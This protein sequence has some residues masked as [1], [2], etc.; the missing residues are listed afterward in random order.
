MYSA[1]AVQGACDNELAWGYWSLNKI[2]RRAYLPHPLFDGFFAVHDHVTDELILNP[3]F[4]YR[5]PLREKS[6]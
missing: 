4:V 3:F 2:C 6:E 5:L 1:I